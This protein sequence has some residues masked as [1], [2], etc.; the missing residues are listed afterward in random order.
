MS[1]FGGKLT[2]RIGEVERGTFVQKLL[3]ADLIPCQE[4]GGIV[5]K[6]RLLLL[7]KE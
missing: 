2:E 5:H 3:D 7:S 4:I 1:S 6:S